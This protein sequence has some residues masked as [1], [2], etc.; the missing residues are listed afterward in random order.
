MKPW[1]ALLLAL[2]A[3]SP[4]GPKLPGTL[5]R[6][7]CT[8]GCA[9]YTV[10]IDDNG[11]VTWNGTNNVGHLGKQT[12]VLTDETRIHVV[13]AA[14]EAG[15]CQRTNTSACDPD[16]PSAVM[17]FDCGGKNKTV[18]QVVGCDGTTANAVALNDLAGTLDMLANTSQW[19]NP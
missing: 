18:T 9:E 13:V 12:A 16:A 14:D 8:A 10:T 7:S 4:P 5:Q 11:N 15:F 17:T 2:A 6:T 3:C 1:L 19:I